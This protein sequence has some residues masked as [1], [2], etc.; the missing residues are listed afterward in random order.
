MASLLAKFRIDYS[1][2]K[3]IPD[4]TKRPNDSTVSLFEEL[5]APFKIV[6]NDEDT[7]QDAGKTSLEFLNFILQGVP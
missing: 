3:L 6:E 2:L 1:D 7:V 4:V 5:I